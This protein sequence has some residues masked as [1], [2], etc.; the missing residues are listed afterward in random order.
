MPLHLSSGGDFQPY[1]NFKASISTWEMSKDG[2]AQPFT[3]TQAIADIENIQQGWGLF[4]EGMA[5]Q[6]VWDEADD[7]YRH[8]PSEGEWKR[9]ISLKFFSPKLFGDDPIRELAS[10]ATGICMGIEN[11][12]NEYEASASAN[13]GKVPVVAFEGVTPKKVGKGN[14]VIP[15][16]KIVK[17]VDRPAAL[18][19][20]DTKTAVVAP[21]PAAAAPAPSVQAPAPAADEEF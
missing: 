12:Y 13:P 18:T 21:S 11:L 19:G 16:L 3:F 17:W 8:K 4:G 9:G 14:T 15:N 20:D 6:W 7:D 10:T 2:G 1:I 5:P